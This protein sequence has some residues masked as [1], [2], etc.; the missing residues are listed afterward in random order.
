MTAAPSI[1][2]GDSPATAWGCLGLGPPSSNPAVL[3]TRSSAVTTYA[4]KDEPE[5]GSSQAFVCFE[6]FMAEVACGLFSH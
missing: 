6:G 1:T 4:S 2:T 3:S 5:I